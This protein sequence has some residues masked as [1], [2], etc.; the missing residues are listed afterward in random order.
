MR[1]LVAEDEQ[2]LS[3]V[4]SSAMTASGYQVDIANNGQEAVEQAKENAYDVIILDIMMPVKSGLEALKE[5]RATGNRTYIMML[6]AMGE[7]DDKV[8]GL[9]AGADDYLS[10]PFSLKEL[11]AR[12]RSRQRRD[13]SYQ[14]DVLEFGDLTLNGNDQSLESHNSISL[15]NRENRL[16]QYFILNANKELSA[17]EL[18]NH[19]WDENE[20][21][22]QEDLWINICYLRQK[23]QAI[24]SQVTISGEKT[25][26]FMIAC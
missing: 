9:D 21:A 7:E 14:V 15:T 10:K 24:Q 1:I 11:L 8:T 22:D 17:N 2:Q 4:L 5:I 16:L 19:V 3:H 6:T 20:T 25:G 26:P 13:D 18:I 12:L 23:L